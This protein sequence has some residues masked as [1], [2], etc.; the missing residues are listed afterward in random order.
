M[1]VVVVVAVV[2]VAPVLLL[3][4]IVATIMVMI[5]TTTR[6]KTD[7]QVVQYTELMF[8][9]VHIKFAGFTRNWKAI[10]RN[11]YLELKLKQC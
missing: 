5:M 1:L 2:V 9:R 3:L 10:Q 11:N 4:P 7:G 8:T 6:Q